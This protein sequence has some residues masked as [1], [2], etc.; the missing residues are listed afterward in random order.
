VNPKQPASTR[1]LLAEKDLTK[2]QPK[3]ECN[4][5]TD[6]IKFNKGVV[7]IRIALDK[8]PWTD[9]EKDNEGNDNK[10]ATHPV[11]KFCANYEF[12]VNQKDSEGAKLAKPL[13]RLLL[14]Y[15]PATGK[16]S[17]EQGPQI[18]SNVTLESL[19]DDKK[20]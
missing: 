3:L 19:V 7:K 4:T 9:T 17:E 1:R 20:M 2:E 12:G 5:A 11:R 18:I 8:V 14:N 13:A 10:L 6:K 16:A 15:D